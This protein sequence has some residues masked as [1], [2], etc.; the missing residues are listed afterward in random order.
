MLKFQNQTNSRWMVLVFL[1]KA[2]LI[3]DC[4]EAKSLIIE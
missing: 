3:F 4:L 1:V 2:G